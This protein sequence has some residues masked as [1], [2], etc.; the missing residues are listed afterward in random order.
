MGRICLRDKAAQVEH[1]GIVRAGLVG[2]DLGQDRVQQ[3]RVMNLR[4][5]NF[6]RR[7]AHFARDQLQPL[8]A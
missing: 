6:G 5:E 1:Q 2:F 4:V 8:F 7:P 3:I